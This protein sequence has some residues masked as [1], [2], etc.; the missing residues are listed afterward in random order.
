VTVGLD[1]AHCPVRERA[2]C[3]ALAPGE[4]ER[5]ARMGHH[6]EIRR[7]ETVFMAGDRNA[8]CATLT[9]G[10][11]KI[12]RHDRDGNERILA[13]IHPSGFVGELFAPFAH[14]DIVALTDSRLCVFSRSQYETMIA[15]HPQLTTA[16]LRRSAED[17]LETRELIDLAG[18][19]S[20]EARVAGLILSFA[21]AASHSPCHS[22]ADF[23]LPLSRGEMASLLG[24]TI[25]TVSRQFSKLESKGLIARQGT[26][27]L[28]LRDPRTLEALVD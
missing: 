18:R 11:L 25:E 23:A 19:R 8:V 17:L 13:L 15:G 20:A 26:R 14:H 27:G 1:C 7:G 2:A 10:A 21:R 5:L 16:L 28:T 4:R 3:A 22:A 6:R 12:V 9:Q 24:L